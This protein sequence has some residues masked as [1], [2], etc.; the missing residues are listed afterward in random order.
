MLERDIEK[1]FVRLAK[2]FNCLCYKWHSQ[3]TK[4]VPD[5][6]LILPN[7][8]VHFV[9]LKTEKGRLSKWQRIIADELVAYSTNY[10]CLHGPKE[11]DKFFK[12]TVCPLQAL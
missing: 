12:E 5:R 11:V 7:G 6:I 9:E 1:R 4:G 2:H 3:S 8:E 10:I